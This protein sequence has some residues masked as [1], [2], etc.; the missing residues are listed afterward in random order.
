MAVKPGHSPRYFSCPFGRIARAGFEMNQDYVEVNRI[1]RLRQRGAFVIKPVQVDV[2]YIAIGRINSGGAQPSYF[3]GFVIQHILLFITRMVGI[4][5]MPITAAAN[6]IQYLLGYG[7]G[8]KS[9]GACCHFLQAQYIG[10]C[11]AQNSAQPNL[12]ITACQ[13][14]A[15][16]AGGKTIIKHIVGHYMQSIICA[17]LCN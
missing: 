1:M 11:I 13:C 17:G 9:S 8:G 4:R 15:T 3:T 5:G 14:W 6:I 7:I 12:F 16:L 2:A 10:L